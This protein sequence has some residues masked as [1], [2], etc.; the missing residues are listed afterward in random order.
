MNKWLCVAACTFIGVAAGAGSAYLSAVPPSLLGYYSATSSSLM[1]QPN[2]QYA[3]ENIRTELQFKEDEQYRLS[4]YFADRELG[5]TVTGQYEYDGE[6]IRLQSSRSEDMLP[7]RPLTFR[8]KVMVSDAS[9]YFNNTLSLIPLSEH[10]FLL[11]S[12]YRMVMLCQEDDAQRC[13]GLNE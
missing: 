8:E 12:P 2:Q 10:H 11:H 6:G 13:G 1:L 4:L 5:T 7:N 3:Y 9:P